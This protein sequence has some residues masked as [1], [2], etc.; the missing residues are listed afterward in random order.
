[1][2]TRTHVVLFAVALLAAPIGTTRAGEHDP[3][4]EAWVE[5]RAANTGSNGEST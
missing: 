5:E 4:P 3:V 1:M 2:T